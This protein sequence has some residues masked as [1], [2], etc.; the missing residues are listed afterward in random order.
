MICSQ[1][2]NS[3]NSLT[4]FQISSEI[5]W[6]DM[7]L[8]ASSIRAAVN[9]LTLCVVDKY[10]HAENYSF[11]S[12]FFS[13]QMWKATNC[14]S[15]HPPRLIMSGHSMCKAFD[16]GTKLTAGRSWGIQIH[17]EQLYIEVKDSPSVVNGSRPELQTHRKAP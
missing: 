1:P 7:Y 6:V 17:H 11:G 10:G 8:N 12:D 13:R 5:L 4:F 16:R 15:S 9:A 3:L 2:N 14:L